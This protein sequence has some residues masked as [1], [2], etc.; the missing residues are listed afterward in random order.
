MT[1]VDLSTWNK[2]T[3]STYPINY[4]DYQRISRDFHF[5]ET[6]EIFARNT[7]FKK[8]FVLFLAMFISLRLKFIFPQTEYHF[9]FHKRK[10]VFSNAKK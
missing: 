2:L 9:L 6:S 10:I 5:L 4:F 3:D 8:F 7:A 1:R